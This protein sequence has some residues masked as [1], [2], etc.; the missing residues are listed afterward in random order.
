MTYEEYRDLIRKHNDAT[1]YVQHPRH[2][3]TKPGMYTDDTQM[4]L[5]IA[6]ALV[7]GDR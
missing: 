5:A 4:S 6:E 3:G 1:H 2:R 7:A